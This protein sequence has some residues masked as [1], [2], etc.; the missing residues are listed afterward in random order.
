[1]IREVAPCGFNVCGILLLA[2][3]H[4]VFIA[5]VLP[6]VTICRCFCPA[7][8]WCSFG[9]VESDLFPIF[10]AVLSALG[11][12]GLCLFSALYA[13]C[14]GVDAMWY[15]L[16]V[17]SFLHGWQLIFEQADVHFVFLGALWV[18][19]GRVV[20]PH[21]S[22]IHGCSDPDSHFLFD[23]FF[24]KTVGVCAVIYLARIVSP[25]VGCSIAIG[26]I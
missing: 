11:T 5:N 6:R 21:N 16:F 9:C 25:L 20:L 19:I 23:D 10:S 22:H 12:I 24:F 13:R 3:A 1:M 26:S 18:A 14:G 7:Y 4:M 8:I 2:C 17:F 15:C